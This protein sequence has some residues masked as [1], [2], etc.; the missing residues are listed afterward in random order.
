MA[1]PSFAPRQ[2]PKAKPAPHDSPPRDPSK[3]KRRPVP[4]DE[5]ASRARARPRALTWSK[6]A[7]V[8]PPRAGGRDGGSRD[9]GVD[10]EEV[11]HQPADLAGPVG[12]VVGEEP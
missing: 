4:Q 11:L 3:Q 12:V 8:S 10:A 7:E 5:A 2:S 9:V 6:A 1:F